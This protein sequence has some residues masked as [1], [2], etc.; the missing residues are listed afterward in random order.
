M[1]MLGVEEAG[2]APAEVH[3]IDRFLTEGTW[4]DYSGLLE[5][6]PIVANFGLDGR[7]VR[8]EAGA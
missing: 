4:K 1:Q 3:G 7:G 6:A 8:C 5:A 2:R